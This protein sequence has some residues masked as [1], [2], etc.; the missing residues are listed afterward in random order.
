[1]KLKKL[2]TALFLVLL[3][4]AGTFPAMAEDPVEPPA[5]P[6]SVEGTGTAFEITDSEYL[7]V[8]LQSSV[9]ITLQLE[10]VPS[11]VM[12]FLEPVEEIPTAQMTVGGLVPSTTYY[13]YEDNYHN[14]EAITTDSSGSYTWVQD[15]SA[16]QQV[17]IQ[18]NPSTKFINDTGGDC[19][20]IGTWDASI[21]TCTLTMDVYETIQIDSDDVTLD[22]NGHVVRGV[23]SGS[24]IYLRNRTG[25]TIKNIVVEIFTD[26][27]LISSGGYNILTGNTASNNEKGIRFQVSYNNNI[28]ST[29]N[30]LIGRS[31]KIP[32]LIPAAIC[33]FHIIN[34]LTKFCKYLYLTETGNI[35]ERESILS[36]RKEQTIFICGYNV[37]IRNYSEIC[38]FLSRSSLKVCRIE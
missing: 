31:I 36:P 11:T 26:G 18:P 25:V 37:R 30:Q 16:S 17:W 19:A 9:P 6:G 28:Y 34:Q 22:G 2:F 15:L 8:T 33:M 20:S 1:M 5:I 7:N 21:K 3:L 13:M 4:F 35:E 29:D 23:G 12:M 27:M 14:K 32:E 38:Y 10:S 24:G